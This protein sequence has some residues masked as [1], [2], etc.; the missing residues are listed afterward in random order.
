MLNIPSS[1][2]EC[3]RVWE[4]PTE[5]VSIGWCATNIINHVHAQMVGL[6]GVSWCDRLRSGDCFGYFMLVE[7]KMTLM[8]SIFITVPRF[9]CISAGHLHVAGLVIFSLWKVL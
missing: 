4:G 7:L 2:H 8:R 1:P 5:A 3:V 6:G 9:L